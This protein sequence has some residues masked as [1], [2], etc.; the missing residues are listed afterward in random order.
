MAIIRVDVWPGKMFI[1][2]EVPHGVR[3]NGEP[4]RL[5]HPTLI[6]GKNARIGGELSFTEEGWVMNNKSGRYSGHDDRGA[7]QL[8]NAAAMMRESGIDVVVNF[9]TPR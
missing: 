8:N 5:G 9:L 2:E 7:E 1:A 3:P 6:G 4:G